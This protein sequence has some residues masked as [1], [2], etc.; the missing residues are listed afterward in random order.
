MERLA[1]ELQEKK[2]QQELERQK[3]EDELKRRT[4]K[5]KGVKDEPQLKRSHAAVSRQVGPSGSVGRV[6]PGQSLSLPDWPDLVRHRDT[7][8]SGGRDCPARAVQSHLSC[9]SGIPQTMPLSYNFI[10]G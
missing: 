6:G 8:D 3:E 4:K 5:A 9:H 10:R 2:L 7:V 1:K